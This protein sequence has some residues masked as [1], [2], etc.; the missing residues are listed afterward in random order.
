[1]LDVENYLITFNLKA[2]RL[3]VIGYGKKSSFFSISKN[4]NLTYLRA[5]TEFGAH[6]L[7]ISG[8]HKYSNLTKYEVLTPSHLREILIF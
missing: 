6:I 3:L 5:P 8:T 1:M 2:A 4:V 7:R